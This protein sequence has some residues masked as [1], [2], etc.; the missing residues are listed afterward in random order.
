MKKLLSALTAI[1]LLAGCASQPKTSEAP[2]TEATAT[3]A[4]VAEVT[5]AELPAARDTSKMY[6]P[7]KD[8]PE[9]ACTEDTYAAGCSGVSV[10]NLVDYLGRDDVLYIDLRDYVD[11][12]KSHLRNF[13]C[14]PY[15]ALIF[16]KEAGSEGKPQLYSGDVT[17]PVAT[18]EESDDLLEEYFPKDKTIFFMCQSGGRVSQLMTLL[19]AKGYDMSKIYNVGGM[20][21]FT[22]AAFE[23]YTVNALEAEV[24]A[25]YAF[26]GLTPAAQ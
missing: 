22:D 4:P 13:E 21:Q 20:G 6:T 15:F 16:D 10:D 23:P 3:E 17:A 19:A 25:T 9:T 1:A 11:Y 24:T 26:N 12:S 2:T 7:G 5:K 8:Q 18:Y 14:I